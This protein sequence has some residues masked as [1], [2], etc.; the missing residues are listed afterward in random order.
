MEFNS[1]DLI[2][3]MRNKC[4]Q[5]LCYIASGGSNMFGQLLLKFIR[6]IVW[7]P[8]VFDNRQRPLKGDEIDFLW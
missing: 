1:S 5:Y 3:D 2:V 8:I 4:Q 7:L 6:I